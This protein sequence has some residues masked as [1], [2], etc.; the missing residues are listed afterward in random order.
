MYKK[1]QPATGSGFV[2]KEGGHAL[3]SESRIL[4]ELLLLVKDQ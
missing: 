1:E 2:R 4:D 3:A